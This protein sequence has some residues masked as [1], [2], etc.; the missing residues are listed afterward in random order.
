[1][2]SFFLGDSGIAC[3]SDLS[4]LSYGVGAFGI[5][6]QLVRTMHSIPT[7]LFAGRDCILDNAAQWGRFGAQEG[8]VEVLIRADTAYIHL[9]SSFFD[10][11]FNTG[12][13]CTETR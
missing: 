4:C 12:G 9:E 13:R 3:G 11:C 1:M 8:G 5:Q 7:S 6:F 2:F 10:L